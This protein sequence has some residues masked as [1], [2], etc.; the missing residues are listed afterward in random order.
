MTFVYENVRIIVY[1]GFI[2]AFSFKS[3]SPLFFG[4]TSINNV[5]VAWVAHFKVDKLNLPQYYVEMIDINITLG[6]VSI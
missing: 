1:V 6:P 2:A 3:Y 5:A 4:V